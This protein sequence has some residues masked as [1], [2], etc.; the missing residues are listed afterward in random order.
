[1]FE[2]LLL[3]CEIQAGKESANLCILCGPYRGLSDGIPECLDMAVVLPFHSD[4]SPA[5]GFSSLLQATGEFFP[6]YALKG[7]PRRF[8]QRIKDFLRPEVFN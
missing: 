7:V 4:P 6:R 1:M 3:L 2:T 5:E 8:T